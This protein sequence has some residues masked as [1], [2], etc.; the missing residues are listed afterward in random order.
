M[1]RLTMLEDV[2]AAD[3][4]GERRDACV[5]CLLAGRAG[6][7]GTDESAD[8]MTELDGARLAAIDVIER[9][10]ARYHGRS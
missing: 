9:L 6:H 10:W 3:T 1:V 8:K 7:A 5:A 2:L 4:Q